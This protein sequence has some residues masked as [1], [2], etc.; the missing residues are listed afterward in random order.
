MTRPLTEEQQGG[1]APDT[2]ATATVTTPAPQEPA[3]AI[4]VADEPAPSVDEPTTEAVDAP[5]A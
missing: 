2:E 5:T 4:A 1:S 3:T